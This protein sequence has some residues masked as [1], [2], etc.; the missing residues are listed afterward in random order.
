MRARPGIG[1]ALVWFV[2]G[3]RDAALGQS[4]SFTTEIVEV[5]SPTNRSALRPAAK[6]AAPPAL[7]V[8]VSAILD[9]LAPIGVHD[10]TM[11][12]TPFKVWQDPQRQLKIGSD[13][14]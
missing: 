1:T 7:A 3:L 6:A 4:P 14:Q 11:P 12:T 2:H 5:L 9:A 10:I 8:I 13:P